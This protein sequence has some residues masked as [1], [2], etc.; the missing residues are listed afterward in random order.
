LSLRAQRDRE[1]RSH[2]VYLRMSLQHLLKNLD[3][4]VNRT[5][6]VK[7]TRAKDFDQRMF[8]FDR[9]ALIEL[10]HRFFIFTLIHEDARAIVTRQHLFARIQPHH[11]IETAQRLF[12]IAVEPRNHATH[13]LHT[14][15]IRILVTQ[16]VNCLARFLL[17]STGEIDEHHVHARL[18]QPR[19]ERQRFSKSILCFLVIARLAQTFQDTIDVATSE[20]GVSECEV[21]IDLDRAPE[22][23][24]RRIEMLT[25]DRVINKRRETVATTQVFFRRGSIGSCLS[26]ELDF[27]I[28]TELESQS[29]DDALHDRVL[30]AD[31][32]AG[33][34]VDSLTPKDLAR[35][36]VEELR[37]H[38]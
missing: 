25:L 15:I 8:G 14:R 2:T 20:R 31:D 12:V 10:A 24:D 36:Y 17:L 6:V 23:F 18:E 4:F 30:H 38:P 26:R 22:V 33:I 16:R 5:L 29:L 34:G 13:K 1:D 21:W 37:R 7:N 27:L 9:L 11:A 32:V 28:R 3:G 35:S 19:I